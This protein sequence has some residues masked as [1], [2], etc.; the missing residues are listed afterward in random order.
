MANNN[1]VSYSPHIKQKNNSSKR[2]YLAMLISLIPAIVFGVIINGINS[3]FIYFVCVPLTTGLDILLNSIKNHKF[4]FNDFSSILVGVLIAMSMPAGIPVYYPILGCIVSVV[5][6]KFCVGGVGKNFVSEVAVAKVLTFIVFANACSKYISIS[7]KELTNETVLMGLLNGNLPEG[8]FLKTFLGIGTGGL[9]ESAILCLLIGGIALCVLKVIDYKIPL[10][11]LISVF[12]FSGI[13]MGF[14]FAPYYLLSGGAVFCAF[15]CLTDYA[16]S[17]DT[18][19]GRILYAFLTGFV[20]VLIWKFSKNYELGAY[21]A[22]LIGG[23]VFGAVKGYYVPKF[24]GE[25][26]HENVK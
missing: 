9:G 21:Y 16:S 25:K 5:F 10:V 3:L 8:G 22:T 18:V 24:A 11:Y 23:L 1:W 2:L 17:P 4:T 20:T 26:K 14:K 12:L 15:Y 6:I 19:L 13:F 7:T